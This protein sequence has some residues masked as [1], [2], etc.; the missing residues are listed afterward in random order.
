MTPAREVCWDQVS[1]V[2]H[3]ALDRPPEE[4]EQFMR[5]ACSD[6]A[7]AALVAALLRDYDAAR[8]FLADSAPVSAADILGFSGAGDSLPGQLLAQRYRIQDV[9]G[10]GGFGVVYRAADERLHGTPVAV[11]VL[12]DYWTS[13]G[14]MRHCFQKEVEALCKVRHPGIVLVT[15][16]GETEDGRMF[17]TMECIEGPTLRE[18]MADGRLPFAEAAN[19]VQAIGQALGAAHARGVLH[20]DLKPENILLGRD[21]VKIVDFGIARIGEA[22]EAGTSRTVALGTLDYMAPEQILGS[23]SQAGDIYSL[24]VIAYEMVAGQRPVRDPGKSL[25]PQLSG[26]KLP[27]RVEHLIK[28][29]LRAAASERPRSAAEYSIALASAFRQ[30]GTF[31]ERVSR[32]RLILGAAAAVSVAAAGFG[33]EEVVA[34]VDLR[35]SQ[36]IVECSGVA[37]E[38]DAGFKP[39]YDIQSLGVMNEDNTGRDRRRIWTNDQGEFWHPLSRSQKAQ[40]WHK[41]FR[42]SAQFLPEQ[43]LIT[44]VVDLSGFGPRFDL[45]AIRGEDGRTMAGVVDQVAPLSKMELQPSD[46]ESPNLTLLELVFSPRTQT[47]AISIDGRERITGYRGHRQ[48]QDNYGVG[49]AVGRYKSTRGAG[50]YKNVRLEIFA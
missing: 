43:G 8:S 44:V 12:H 49:I 27:A 45:V 39:T 41:G 14:W 3:E 40:A 29:A 28:K 35:E 18:R 30:C 50:I 26:P 20:R 17:L 24:G 7:P 36:R 25:E 48:W 13:S 5:D 1:H 9:I 23:C 11:K 42:L 22:G 6:A 4:R 2:F 10:R 34:G 33:V 38:A 46:R 16:F 21:G 32:R 19:I 15:D 31:R 47:A 37:A